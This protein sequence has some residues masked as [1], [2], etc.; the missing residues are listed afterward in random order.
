MPPCGGTQLPGRAEVERLTTTRRF[1]SDGVTRF[2]GYYDVQTPYTLMLVLRSFDRFASRY[3]NSKLF[4]D[5]AQLPPGTFDIITPLSVRADMIAAYRTLVDLGYCQDVDGFTT[6]IVVE[7]AAND[8]NRL[9]VDLPVRLVTGLR[10]F[11]G[12]V[13]FQLGGNS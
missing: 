11:A 4:A 10:V 7:L 12:R 8:P 9:N 5:N 2:D 6:A 1:E 13:S 3:Q